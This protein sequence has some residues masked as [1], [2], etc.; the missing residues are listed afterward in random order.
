MDDVDGP[1]PAVDPSTL[2]RAIMRY[3][4]SEGNAARLALSG[5]F[6]TARF[7]VHHIIRLVG[8]CS[9]ELGRTLSTRSI[10]RAFDIKH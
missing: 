10:A 5:E 6:I 1:A 9:S 7:R 8:C 3:C 4:I 2:L